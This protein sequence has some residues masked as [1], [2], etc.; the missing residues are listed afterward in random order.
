VKTTVCLLTGLAIIAVGFSL[1]TVIENRYY[2]FAAYVIL[3][4]ITRLL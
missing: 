3:Q 2:F 4:Y 1:T